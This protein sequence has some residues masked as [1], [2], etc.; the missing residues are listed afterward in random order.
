MNYQEIAQAALHACPRLLFAWLPGGRLHGYEY[1]VLNPTRDDRTTGNFRINIQTGK[2]SDF[3]TRES[4]GDLIALRAW[5]DSSSQSDAAHEIERQ[6]GLNGTPQSDSSIAPFLFRMRA[7]ERPSSESDEC[8]CPVPDD[9]PPPPLTAHHAA[10]TYTN[11]HGHGLGYVIRIDRADGK[12][13]F[14]PLTFWKESG[15]VKKSWPR[16]APLYNQVELTEKLESPVLVVEGEKTADAAHH[17]FPN[18]AAV[19][20]PGGSSRAGHADWRQ[21]AGRSVWLLPDHDEPGR[22][23]MAVIAEILRPIVRDLRLAVLPD[24]LPEG[25]DVADSTWD[26]HEDALAWL[27]GLEWTVLKA[28]PTSDRAPH[29]EDA[30]FA[31]VLKRA[32]GQG[33]KFQSI[34]ETSFPVPPLPI[35]LLAQI[36]SEILKRVPMR[37]P[38]AAQIAAKAVM[39]HVSGRQAVSQVGDP[40]HL[41]LALVAPSIGD[42]RPYLVAVRNLLEQ[43]N[44]TK[45]LRSQRLSNP[46]QIFRLLWRSPSLLYFSNEWGTVLQFAKRQPAGMAEQALTMMSEVWDGQ[47]ITADAD[48]LKIPDAKDDGQCL[49]RAPHLTMLLTLSHDQLATA[50]KLSEMGRG[51]LEQIQY[52]IL[53]DSEFEEADPDDLVNDPFPADLVTSLRELSTPE[54]SG[55]LSGLTGPD[56]P[57]QRVEARFTHKI[58]PFYAPMEAL[59]IQRSARSLVSSARMIARREATALAF[60]RDRRTPVITADLMD[61]AVASETERLRRILNRF[62]SL[63]TEDGKMSAYEKVLDFIASEKTKGAGTRALQQYCHAYRNLSDDK[64]EALIKQLLNDGAIVE[65]YPES[66]PGAR[67][68]AV[69]YVVKSFAQAIGS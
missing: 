37:C 19:T 65:V 32:N 16:P 20:W 33:P 41:Y 58:A 59:P 21:L 29:D 43:A 36:E 51:A 35:P 52:W 2:W 53:E 24:S 38:R 67:R 34:V 10:W 15:W 50:L 6:L 64:R 13:E 3:A 40:T 8:L 7:R 18:F 49:I 28:E 22:K 30:R 54:H 31:E 61:A 25:W 4:G 12:K 27:S 57:P 47:V 1:D 11:P 68:K 14:R 26:H 63:S 46:T 48:E 44:M 45:S 69:V 17:G 9:A 56:L 66:K 23:A 55:N 60:F 42:V 62:N 39:A 5:L